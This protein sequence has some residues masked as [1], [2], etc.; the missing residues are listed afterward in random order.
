M[1]DTPFRYG[2]SAPPAEAA[3]WVLSFWRF[4]VDELPA[5]GPPYTVWPDGCVSIAL[6][7]RGIPGPGVLI[8]GPR[9]TA[10]RPPLRSHTRLSGIR[11][12]PDACREVLGIAPRELRNAVGPASDDLAA[13]FAPLRDQLTPALSGPEAFAVLAGWVREQVPAWTPPDSQVRQAVRAI[14]A[15]RGEV[16]MPDVAREATLGLRQLQRRFAAATGLTLREWARVRRLRESLAHHMGGA[17]GGWSEV[18]ASTGFADHS[19][20]TREFV[21]LT[22]LPP[23]VAAKQLSA[24]RHDQVRP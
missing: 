24:T 9:V 6:L 5:G 14:V 19:H 20:L 23:S 4:A 2:E 16:S 12:W 13:R 18:A 7:P 3:E 8:T 21:A 1:T 22:G 17:D 15:A 10:M 11:L